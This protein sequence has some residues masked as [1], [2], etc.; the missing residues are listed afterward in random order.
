MPT[1]NALASVSLSCEPKQGGGFHVRLQVWNRSYD[2]PDAARRN[3]LINKVLLTKLT[4][5]QNSP[6]NVHITDRYGVD[7]TVVDDAARDRYRI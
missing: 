6:T 7:E 5:N 2:H 4:G 3:A 1:R